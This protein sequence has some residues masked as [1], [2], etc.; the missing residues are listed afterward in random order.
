M[1]G[2]QIFT[3]VLEALVL[4]AEDETPV[5]S[6]CDVTLDDWNLH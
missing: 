5:K 1:C 6:G 2:Q 4:A 3:T